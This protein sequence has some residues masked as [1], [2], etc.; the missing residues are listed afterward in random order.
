MVRRVAM[1]VVVIFVVVT[2]SFFMVRLMP[3]NAMEY[4]E[5]QLQLQGGLTAQQINEKVQ[6]IYGLAPTAPLWKQYLEYI[7]H[8]AQ[9]NLGTSVL[10]PGQ[11]VMSIVASAAPWTIFC[12]G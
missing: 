7:A 3:G 1:A 9:G 5:A 12:V 11:S 10:N 6:A 2:I 4:V 8:A